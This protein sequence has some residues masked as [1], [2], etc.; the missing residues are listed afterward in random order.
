LPRTTPGDPSTSR[1]A[2]SRERIAR[3]ALEL[4]DR[5]GVEALTMRRLAAELGVGTMTLYGYFRT[6]EELIDAAVDAVIE[7]AGVRIRGRTW[8]DQLANLMRDVRRELARHPAGVRIRLSRPLISPGALRV[9]EAGMRVLESAGFDKRQAARAYESLLV[10][11]LG[12]ATFCSPESAEAVKRQ[13]RAALAVLPP[14]EYPAVTGAGRELTETLF[15]DAQFEFG[16]ERLL[17]GLEAVLS[18]SKRP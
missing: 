17:D 6:K 15:G 7:E 18:A 11:T 10:Y 1:G 9:T 2:L 3:S 16:L 4:L 14:E 13:A 8:R 12:F 5:E